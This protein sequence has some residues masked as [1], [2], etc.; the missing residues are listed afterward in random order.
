MAD[1]SELIL[2]E[3]RGM[4]KTL[5]EGQTAMAD[6]PARLTNLEIDMGE[7]KA[8]IRIIKIVVSDLSRPI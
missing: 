8:D 4:F 6:V 3:I 5:R 2:E 1:R 7:V